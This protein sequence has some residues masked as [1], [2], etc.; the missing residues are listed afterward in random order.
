MHCYDDDITP[1]RRHHV[2][3]ITHKPRTATEELCLREEGW[4]AGDR[5]V[6]ALRSSRWA[7]SPQ[8]R[9]REILLDLC[10]F[11]YLTE[12]ITNIDT[13]LLL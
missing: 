10:C 9:G 4:E 1:P 5:P 12:Q 13:Q 7:I 3:S 2:I 6:K 11:P 8:F